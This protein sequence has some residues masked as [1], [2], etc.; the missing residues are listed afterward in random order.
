MEFL[1]SQGIVAQKEFTTREFKSSYIVHTAMINPGSSGGGG[2]FNDKGE[3][4]WG[5]YI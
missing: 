5:Q 1:V 2:A 4:D 3:L